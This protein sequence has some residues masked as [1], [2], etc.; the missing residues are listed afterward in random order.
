MR[1]FKDLKIAVAGTGYVGLSIATLLAQHHKVIA[2][3]IILEKVELINNRK[4][5]IQDDYIEKYLAEKDL[6]LTATL[7]AKES[8]AD[9]DFVVIAAPT[10]YDSKKNFFD[11]SAVENVIGLVMEYAPDAIMVIKSTIPVGYTKSIR[12]KTGSKNIIF[13]PEF[14]RES[15]ALYDNLYPSRIIVG[16]DMEDERLAEAAHTFAELLQEGAIK[17]NIDTLFM[18]FTEAEAVKLFANTYLALRVAYFN[19]LDTYAEMKGLNTQQIIKGVCLD[20]RVGDFYNN[21]SFGYG[22][23]CLPKDTK[24]LLVNYQDVPEN[25]I[26]AIVESNRTRKDFI[27]DRVL[28]IAGAYGANDSWDESREK[29]VVV[30]V[31]RLTMKSNSDNFRQSSIQGVMKRIKAKGAIVIIYEPTM[32]DGDTFFGSKVVNDLDEFKR[33]SQ[34]IIA[35]RYDKCLDEVK[36]K[37]Y[38]R[39]IFQRD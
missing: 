15:K 38:T 35:N 30:G 37:V 10:N 12:E 23:Y 31:Y 20:P 14:L 13:S 27:A 33:Q 24:Q 9:A 28:E 36:E 21:P 2:V 29:E 17:E 7:D 25:L 3:D 8:Y 22:G 5:P 1:E 16:T 39:D 32:K 11:T 4:S 26:E 34:A 6:N 19:E 18:G